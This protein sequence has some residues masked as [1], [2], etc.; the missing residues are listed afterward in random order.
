MKRDGNGKDACSARLAKLLYS[1]QGPLQ[2]L[3]TWTLT[4]WLALRSQQSQP[5][6]NS[7]SQE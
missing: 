4:I 7:T 5:E 2:L 3:Y 6:S 1:L